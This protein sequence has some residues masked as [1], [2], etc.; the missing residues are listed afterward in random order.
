MPKPKDRDKIMHIYLNKGPKALHRY[1]LRT[2]LPK[3]FLR[4]IVPSP[5]KKVIKKVLGR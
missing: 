5:L 4:R 3:S 2:T 1:F